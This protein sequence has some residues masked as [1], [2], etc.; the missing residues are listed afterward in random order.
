[1]KLNW[2]KTIHLRAHHCG[3]LLDSDRNAIRVTEQTVY[4]GSFL[5]ASGFAI[6]TAA[7]RL[8]EA[9]GPFEKIREV[10]KHANIPRARMIQIYSACVLAEFIY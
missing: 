1:M 8:G 3:D 10:W 4:L 5:T 2:K 9:R 6:P 7:K